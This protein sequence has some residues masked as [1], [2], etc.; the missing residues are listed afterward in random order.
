M[1]EIKKRNLGYELKFRTYLF[2][3]DWGTHKKICK[4]LNVKPNQLENSKIK[5][6]Q[7]KCLM[8]SGMISVDDDNI[9]YFI[10]ALKENGVEVEE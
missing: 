2:S 3:F 10:D 4:N 5:I 6:S 9:E 1:N 8:D 7:I